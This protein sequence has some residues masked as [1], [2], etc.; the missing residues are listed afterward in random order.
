MEKESF[1]IARGDMQDRVPH[2]FATKTFPSDAEI[3]KDVD[4]RVCAKTMK[5]QTK[6]RARNGFC[7]NFF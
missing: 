3:L 5:L 1:Q 2:N 4:F 7:S 6:L